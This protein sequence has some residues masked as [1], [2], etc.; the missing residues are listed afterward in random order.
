MSL[1]IKQHSFGARIQNG[2]V[3][4]FRCTC[5]LRLLIMRGIEVFGSADTTPCDGEPKSLTFRYEPMSAVHR[6]RIEGPWKPPSK[7]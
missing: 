5:C 3:S 1:P 4:Y 6:K 2:D 7:G